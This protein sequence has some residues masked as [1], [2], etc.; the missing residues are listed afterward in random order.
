MPAPGHSTRRDLLAGIAATLAAPAF[1]QGT[2][3]DVIVV[4]AGIAGCAAA[5]ALTDAGA[6]VRVIEARPRIGGRIHS[7]RTLGA[8][9]DMGAAWLHGPHGNPLTELARAESLRLVATDWE[10][11][12]VPGR[13][14]ADI[15]A[16]LERTEAVLERVDALAD[17]GTRLSA[18]LDRI[19][20]D[21]RTDPLL[22]LGLTLY[23]RFDGGAALE[24]LDASLWDEDSAFGGPDLLFAGGADGLLPPLV[25]G[26]DIRTGTPVTRIAQDGTGVTV[27]TADGQEA[28]AGHVVVTLPLGV[29]KAD[30]VRFEPSL[31]RRQRGA[32]ARLG[33]GQVA[34]VALAFDRV[35]WPE[36]A[37]ALGSPEDTDLPLFIPVPNASVIVGIA[38]GHAASTIEAMSDSVA[39]GHAH[40][41]LSRL[42]GRDLPTARAA[43]VSRW[44]RDP[45]AGLAYSVAAPG[46]RAGDFDALA[47]P[48]GRLHLAGEHTTGAH[49]GTLHGALLSGRR[50]AA[51]ILRDS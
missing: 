21:H 10:S 3:A 11:L 46:T 48:A 51:V 23:A 20:P 13:S 30:G 17:P 1:A 40:A 16:A 50:A 34:K 14:R 43:A 25:R 6:Q 41:R 5:R 29:L 27:S 49:R 15:T 8:P 35:H 2:A 47:A 28:R 36:G 19:A 39:A 32:I 33:A 26:I 44:G 9:V 22:R 18:M 42:L 4:G 38:V 12:L 31:P 7:L 24:D 37:D 45:F